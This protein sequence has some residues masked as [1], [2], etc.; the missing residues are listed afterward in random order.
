MNASME[1]HFQV[2][3]YLMLVFFFVDYACDALVSLHITAIKIGGST[4]HDAYVSF[5]GVALG[6]ARGMLPDTKT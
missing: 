4:A 1:K 3:V 5:F 2:A 6:I